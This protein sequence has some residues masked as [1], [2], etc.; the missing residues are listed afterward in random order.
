M[1]TLGGNSGPVDT[2]FF[3]L[4]GKRLGSLDRS[5]TLRV[6][7]L[8]IEGLVALAKER[9]SRSFTADECQRYL[10]LEACP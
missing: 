10:H 6:Y 8:Q 5:R 9:V 4:D 2:V 1:Y 7:A 3:S